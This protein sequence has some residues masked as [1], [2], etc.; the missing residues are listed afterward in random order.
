M[1]PLQILVEGMRGVVRRDCLGERNRN[2]RV[3]L[4][5]VVRAGRKEN[6]STLSP[7][8]LGASEV[9][10]R[11]LVPGSALVQILHA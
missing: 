10:T 4:D 7:E 3:A 2:E 8:N 6:K 11:K 1:C 5:T 9:R